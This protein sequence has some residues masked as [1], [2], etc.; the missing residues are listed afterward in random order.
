[1]NFNESQFDVQKVVVNRREFLSSMVDQN[2]LIGSLPGIRTVDDISEM[3]WPK[4]WTALED[5]TGYRHPFKKIIEEHSTKRFTDF[6]FFDYKQRFDGI[7][8]MVVLQDLNE[9]TECVGQ[10]S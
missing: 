10:S 9:D 1:M 8:Y 5:N 2:L 4:I 7:D 3:P 6:E